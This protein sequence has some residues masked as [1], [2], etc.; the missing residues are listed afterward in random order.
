MGEGREPAA[1]LDAAFESSGFVGPLHGIPVIVKDQFDVTGMPTTLDSILFKDYYPDRDAF[2]TERLKEAGAIIL[3]KAT[4]GEL[5][6]G[7]THGSLFGSTR[8]PLY[9][10]RPIWT[11]GTTELET[12]PAVVPRDAASSDSLSVTLRA[13]RL[14]L[15]WPI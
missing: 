10:V 1:R 14:G 3:A 2:V 9:V 7:D 11:T 15:R 6:G 8:N 13:S 5:A 4:L 12:V